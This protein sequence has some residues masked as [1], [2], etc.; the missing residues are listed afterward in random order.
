MPLYAIK[1]YAELTGRKQTRKII[2]SNRE[3]A[4]A[5]VRGE[6]IFPTSCDRV[7]DFD[8][9]VVKR[10][11]IPA[12]HLRSIHIG[13]A[14]QLASETTVQDSIASLAKSVKH[15]GARSVLQRL[16][17]ELVQGV[18]L[19]EA[20]AIYP[21]IWPNNVCSMIRAGERNP[22]NLPATFNQI[23]IYYD[24]ML[25]LKRAVMQKL[26]MP[27]VA[28]G[29]SVVVM[30]VLVFF[31]LP[32]MAKLFTDMGLRDK[33]PAFTR[34]LV[35]AGEWIQTNYTVMAA[36]A[37]GIVAVFAVLSFTGLLLKLG[38]WVAMK[39]PFLREV[40][41]KSSH[42]RFCAVISATYPATGSVAEAL[43]YAVAAI[44]EPRMRAAGNAALK[45]LRAGEGDFVVLLR[46]S[47]CFDEPLLNCLAPERAKT[48][49]ASICETFR[50][51]YVDAVRVAGDSLVTAIELSL[52][53]LTLCIVLFVAI[54]FGT[55]MMT[56]AVE[57]SGN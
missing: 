55:P 53:A 43:E 27:A 18:P 45:R 41:D 42:A 10:T 57:L 8:I 6:R 22:A 54:A 15:R 24:E 3:E 31:T 51:V 4:E 2:A 9:R 25:G 38:W 7:S 47:G 52:L 14:A 33:L 48:K 49:M 40:L 37:A 1:G 30:G 17:S 23:A 32:R 11:K 46:A 39:T 26:F 21:L 12:V 16:R 13:L 35:D 29:M 36:G 5:L 19:S 28:M 20:M 50:G 56:M 44:P 34:G